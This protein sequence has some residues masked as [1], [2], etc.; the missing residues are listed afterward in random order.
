MTQGDRRSAC[1]ARGARTTRRGRR[2]ASRA[3]SG[4]LPVHLPPRSTRRGGRR[5]RSAPPSPGRGRGRRG[6]RAPPP[7]LP[8]PPAGAPRA[9]SA[10]RGSRSARARDANC[11]APGDGIGLIMAAVTE[12]GTTDGARTADRARTILFF[13]EGAYGPTNNCVG[14]GQVLRD[15]GHRVVFIVEESFAGRLE[16]Q[17]F[18]ERR[19]RLGPA[20][21]QEEV[22][23][24]F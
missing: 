5:S 23:G 11:R 12:S 3:D 13:P 7:R 18:E 8:P 6:S 15:R 9:T 14:I 2:R 19:M 21:E 17:G 22:P 10:R 1:G 4:R 16:A 20:P 24:Q